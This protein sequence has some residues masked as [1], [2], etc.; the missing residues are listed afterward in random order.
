M[1]APATPSFALTTRLTARALGVDA[2]VLTA[3]LRTATLADLPRILAFRVALV[4]PAA[5]ADDERYLRWRYR[6]GRPVESATAL[7]ELWVLD[8][9]GRLLALVGTEELTLMAAGEPLRAERPM[10]LQI[11]AGVVD[12]G[13]GVWMNQA[14]AQR[15]GALLAIGGNRNSRGIVERLFTPLA[16]L[17]RYTYVIDSRPFL[18]KSGLRGPAMA[19]MAAVGNLVLRLREAW[20]GLARGARG[21][22]DIRPVAR[23]APDDALADSR[24]TDD[25]LG[26]VRSAAGLNHRLFDNPRACYFVAAAYAGARRVG[27]IVWRRQKGL[28]GLPQLNVVDAWG[29]AAIR[30]RVIGALVMHV[31]E[32]ARR[33]GC[34]ALRLSTGDRRLAALLTRQGFA[35]PGDAGE[36]MAMGILTAADPSRA[37]VLAALRCGIT[38]LLDDDDGTWGDDTVPGAGL[39]ARGA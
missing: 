33:E 24:P 1:K 22:F 32:I 16:P 35:S 10:D 28:Q 31:I 18:S 12:S 38:A 39:L 20:I 17:R 4:G 9:E 27:A 37:Q 5:G 21:A 23:F 2:A 15:A 8:L 11:A 26:I 34:H 36:G 13:L 3:A 6:L 14:A 29:E 19:A 30:D 25:K 7:G